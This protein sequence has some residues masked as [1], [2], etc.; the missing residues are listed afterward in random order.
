[1]ESN[2]LFCGRLPRP[3]SVSPRGSPR[4]TK[5]RS[6]CKYLQSG[7]FLGLLPAFTRPPDLSANRNSSA[8]HA[9]SPLDPRLARLRSCRGALVLSSGIAVSDTSDAELLPLRG[10][11]KQCPEKTESSTRADLSVPIFTGVSPIPSYCRSSNFRIACWTVT[12]PELLS[13]TNT[14]EITH[15]ESSR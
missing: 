13:L 4:D 11:C 14:C 2:Y 8:G 10:C 5:S 6:I 7:P 15:G 9:H 3:R 1:M 12:R